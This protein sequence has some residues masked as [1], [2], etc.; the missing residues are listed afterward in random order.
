MNNFSWYNPTRVVFGSGTIANLGALVP[1]TGTV[2]MVYGGGSIKKNGVYQQVKKALGKR[3]VVE[4]AG[5]EPNPRYETCMKAVAQ[6]RKSR[7]A[8]LLAVGGG[9]VGDAVKFI[10][11]ALEFK[12]GDPW[13]ILSRRAEIKS[14]APLGCVIT[15]PATGT[16]ANP[17]AVISRDATGEKLSFASDKVR[18]VFSILDPET[19]FTL[20]RRQ[21]A[22]GIIDTF[23]HVCEQYVT[24]PNHATLQDRQAEAVLLALK[25][26][27]PRLIKNPKSYDLRSDMMYA[28]YQGLNQH[29]G[30]GVPQDWA[31]H[32]IGH[33]LTALYGLDH[34]VTLAIV[35]PG[36]WEFDKKRKAKKLI[37]YA[38]R[39]WGVATGTADQRIGAAIAKT[40]RFYRS[41][42]VKTTLAE[43][44]IGADAPGI[45]RGRLADRNTPGMGEHGDITPDKV[46][47]ILALRLKK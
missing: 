24:F 8:F 4:F 32:D 10:A 41:L 31:T 22:N 36:V 29:L 25:E 11:A 15:L 6:A 42:G 37:Q 14:A 33:E 13:T 40:D 3:K 18:P 5:I 28:A 9:S 46:E 35:Q 45:V 23:V 21:T 1:R 19:T 20:D 27:G 30:C 2:M 39:V 43:Y 38:E 17:N 12:G 7:A 47:K 34:A 44:K 26:I 16:E